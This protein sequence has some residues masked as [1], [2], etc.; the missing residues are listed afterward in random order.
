MEHRKILAQGGIV[1]YWIDKVDGASDC[2]V[3]T[4]GLTAN[5]TMYEKQVDF[6]AGKYTVLLWDVAFS[7]PILILIGENDCTGKV[8]AYC[9]EWAKRTGYPLH[10]IKGAKHFS[11][12]DNPGQVNEEI[13]NFIN[14]LSA[15]GE[16]GN[17]LL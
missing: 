4:H 16:I 7:F 15:K 8:K 14:L 3:F 10:I 2:I 9:R 1:H 12:G 6:F 17:A 5:H 13:E 11:N